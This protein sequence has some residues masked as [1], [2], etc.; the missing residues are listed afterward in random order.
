MSW[1]KD[2]AWLHQFWRDVVAERAKRSWVVATLHDGDIS[3]RDGVAF[4]LIREQLHGRPVRYQFV[5]AWTVADGDPPPPTEDVLLIGR[6]KPYA[7][8]G[9]WKPFVGALES[10]TRFPEK[11]DVRTTGN[12]VRFGEREFRRQEL[13]TSPE[14]NYRRCD[15]D[16]GILIV[17]EADVGGGRRRLVAF[18]GL[19]TLGTLGLT[20]LLTDAAR[21]AELAAEVEK[22]LP[23]RDSFRPHESVEICVRIAVAGEDQLAN[24]LNLRQF[25]F[26]VEAVAMATTRGP[27]IALAPEAG[28]ELWLIPDEN[29]SH[30]GRVRVSGAEDV[31]LTPPRFELLRRLVESPDRPTARTLCEHLSRTL[32]IANG[33]SETAQRL[34]VAKLAHDLNV[35]LRKQVPALAH[36]RVVR[37]KGKR[38]LIHGVRGIAPPRGVDQG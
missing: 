9:A 3:L 18:S 15:V 32:G 37:S 28:P 7:L 11:P 25:S 5:R 35:R 19:S 8:A 34:R 21:R 17:K 2:Y 4:D 26:R 1:A 23:W 16:Y 14:E 12:K 20:I 30:G 36:A 24:I 6:P 27:R 22:V 10:G 38:Y 29:G 13:E 31:W 33:G